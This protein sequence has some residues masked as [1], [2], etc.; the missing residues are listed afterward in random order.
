[1]SEILNLIAHNPIYN[2]LSKTLFTNIETNLKNMIG[3]NPGLK[4]NIYIHNCII[5]CLYIIWCKIENYC[6][7]SYIQDTR[8]NSAF[9]GL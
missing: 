2:K 5:H 7:I 9:A 3:V 1:M 8:N 4:T 6:T